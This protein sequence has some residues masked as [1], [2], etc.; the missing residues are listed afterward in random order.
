MKS[1]VITIDVEIKVIIFANY[2]LNYVVTHIDKMW[3]H[4]V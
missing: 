2:F 3:A 4:I 1:V